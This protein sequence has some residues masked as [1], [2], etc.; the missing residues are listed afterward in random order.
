MS[1]D[2]ILLKPDDLD[3]DNLQDL[4][5]V[6]EIGSES[7]VLDA[8]NAVFPGCIDGFFA[9]GETYT[10]E[11]S[12]SG[13]PVTS[14]HLSLRFGAA[15]SDASF[16]QVEQQLTRLCQSLEVCAFSVDDNSRL[17]GPL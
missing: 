14:V 8:L 16:S 13:Q 5:E 11:G 7:F 3:I 10:V 6:H 9:H 12:L 4:D 1:Y 2:I 17:A 15:W